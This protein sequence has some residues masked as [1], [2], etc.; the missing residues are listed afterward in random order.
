MLPDT[1]DGV[2][3]TKSASSLILLLTAATL[4]R[5]IIAVRGGQFYWHDER[6]YLRSWRLAN[7]ILAGDFRRDLWAETDEKPI[8]K[9]AHPGY[10]FAALPAALAQY[11]YCRIRGWEITD[12]PHPDSNW[13]PAFILSWASVAAIGLVYAVAR[14]SGG[15]P[16]EALAAAVLM[17]CSTA[18]LCFARHFLPYDV[19]LMLLLVTLWMGLAPSPQWWHSVLV[20][21]CG[22]LT[23]LTYF[24]SWMALGPVLLIHVLWSSRQPAAVVRRLTILGAVVIALPAALQMLTVLAGLT[25]FLTKLV[26]FIDT[27]K[28]GDPREGATLVWAYLWHAEKGLLLLWLVMACDAATRLRSGRARMWLV[29]AA[30][31]YLVFVVESSVLGK[32]VVYGRLARQLVPFLCLAGGIGVAACWAGCSRWVRSLG[33]LC[34]SLKWL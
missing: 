21:L 6:R 16:A 24:G 15:T 20:G 23:F 30:G 5:L 27:V 11:G 25:P 10:I 32:Q 7:R 26:Q 33:G 12:P 17:S 2:K 28:Q 4:M 8:I 31:I 13:L 19:G 14:R 18:M 9:G 3:L 29:I 1:I 34:S 22:G